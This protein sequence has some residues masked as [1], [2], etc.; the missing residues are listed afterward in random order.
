MKFVL[1]LVLSLTSLLGFSESTAENTKMK[2]QIVQF[3]EQLKKSGKY[4]PEQL[5]LAKKQLEGMDDADF[6][7]LVNVAK[8]KSQ[9][10]KMRAEAMKVLGQ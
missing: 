2:A 3:I 8:E 5:E 4:S 10:P 1:V 6:A 9:D 7:N